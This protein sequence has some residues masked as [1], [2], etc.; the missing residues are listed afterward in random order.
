MHSLRLAELN[1]NLSSASELIREACTEIL[2]SNI[3]PLLVNDSRQIESIEL[4]LK[5][6]KTV[7]EKKKSGD[8]K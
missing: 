4:N 2:D 8:L 1:K 3:D 7:L 6:L 5:Q